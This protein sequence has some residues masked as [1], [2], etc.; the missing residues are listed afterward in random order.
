M[1]HGD[2]LISAS[3]I[4]KSSK[5]F[6]LICDTSSESIVKFFFPN[7]DIRS[8]NFRSIYDV[9]KSSFSSIISSLIKIFS[10]LNSLNSEDRIF[11]DKH[12]FRSLILSC[13][14]KAKYIRNCFNDENI[15]LSRL[16]YIT[17]LNS[18][19]GNYYSNIFI[20]QKAKIAYFP[21]SRVS[22]KNILFETYSKIADFLEVYSSSQSVYKHHLDVEYANKFSF[23]NYLDINELVS[24]I[25][26]SDLL[27]VCDSLV[28]HVAQI[29][30]KPFW[31]VFNENV[32][33]KWL[34]PGAEEN[35]ILIR[36]GKIIKVGANV[37]L[38]DN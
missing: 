31:V 7:L 24:I 26:G 32:N 17:G 19:D 16:N 30:N 4:D 14:T 13:L 1:G 29:L 20:P 28:L 34:P 36:N 25:N 27:I 21:I 15:Y 11:F 9:K 33:H 38:N 10:L 12:D 37:F 23:N 18:F 8:S 22:S 6:V 35:Y 3:I 5:K 2:A